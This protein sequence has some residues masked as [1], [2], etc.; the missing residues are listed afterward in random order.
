M[1]RDTA[2]ALLRDLRRHQVHIE[3]HD[4][5]LRIR[6]P[7][8]TVSDRDREALRT[9]K[10]DLLERLGQEEHLLSLALD[11]F[12]RQSYSIELAVPWLEE[13]IWFVP[14]TEHIDGLIRDGVKRGQIWTANELTDLFAE[15]GFDEQDIIAVGRLKLQF[16]AE[17]VLV[18]RDR[19]PGEGSP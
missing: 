4:D 15:P 12:A 11:E 13:T 16:G 19:G 7:M 17:I 2:V 1:S 18:E 6:A 10:P 3:A 8:G 5:R 14:S 9:L